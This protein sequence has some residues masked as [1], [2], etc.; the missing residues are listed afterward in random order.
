MLGSSYDGAAAAPAA[1]TGR[2]RSSRVVGWRTWIAVPRDDEW[3]LWSVAQG[4]PWPIRRPLTAR[5]PRCARPPG[6]AC[7]CGVHALRE[8][9]PLAPRLATGDGTLGWNVSVSVVGRVALSGR[10]VEAAG[11]W[12]AER[13]YP[14]RL[15]VIEPTGDAG[16]AR[17]VARSLGDYEVPV[18]IAG[19]ADPL[20]GLGAA[21]PEPTG[22]GARGAGR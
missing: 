20:A 2:G 12:R 14:S 16:L 3:R 6:E 21:A 15:W 11:G 1:E 10:V 9:G 8:P 19:P 4:V 22:A 7:D 17:A 13:A 18:E 5:C